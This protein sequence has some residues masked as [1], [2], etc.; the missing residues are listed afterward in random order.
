MGMVS[1]R[2]TIRNYVHPCANLQRKPVAIPHLRSLFGVD[3]LFN[4]WVQRVTTS[5]WLLLLKL[6]SLF[7]NAPAVSCVTMFLTCLLYALLQVTQIKT[8]WQ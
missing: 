1:M 8:N 5:K 2:C 3:V 4:H 6:L 7:D